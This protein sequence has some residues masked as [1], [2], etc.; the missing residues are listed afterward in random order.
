MWSCICIWLKHTALNKCSKAINL[1]LLLLL[2]ANELSLSDSREKTSKKIY[3]KMKQYKNTIQTIQNWVNTS[4]HSTKT[5]THY[6]THTSTH[7]LY[8]VTFW[9]L[10]L[11]CFIYI[12]VIGQC[13]GEGHQNDRMQHQNMLKA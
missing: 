8:L 2:T 3:T 7:P 6:K 5:N 1:L 9:A 4:T 13:C 12:Y 10:F 11:T